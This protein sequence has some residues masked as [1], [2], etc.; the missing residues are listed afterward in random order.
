MND[1]VISFWKRE[2]EFKSIFI[3]FFFYLA[4][5]VRRSFTILNCEQFLLNCSCP[6]IRE[7]L[8]VYIQSCLSLKRFCWAFLLLLQWKNGHRFFLEKLWFY[9]CGID[10][11][12][13]AK[14]LKFGQNVTARTFHVLMSGQT[15]ETFDPLISCSQSRFSLMIESLDKSTHSTCFSSGHYDQPSIFPSLKCPWLVN[16]SHPLLLFLSSSFSLQLLPFLFLFFFFFF[17]FEL[18]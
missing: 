13:L 6:T 11:D 18:R 9:C 8:V 2:R 15:T 1:L 14:K 3:F 4:V 7:C 5:L 12:R 17:F 10:G 16:N